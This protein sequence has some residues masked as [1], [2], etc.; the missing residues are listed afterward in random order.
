MLKRIFVDSNNQKNYCQ[1]V[2][3]LGRPIHGPL[4]LFRIGANLERLEREWS[5]LTASHQLVFA[6]PHDARQ[7][8]HSYI[9]CLSGLVKNVPIASV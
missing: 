8:Q 6:L 4:V 9:P 1:L 2:S 5:E 7:D 3:D